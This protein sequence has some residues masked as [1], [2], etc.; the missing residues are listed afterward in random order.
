[1]GVVTGDWDRPMLMVIF[2]AGASYDSVPSRRPGSNIDP[3]ESKYR[4]PLANELFDDRPH[5][6]QAMTHFPKCQVIVPYLRK[7]TE[8]FSLEGELEKLRSEAERDPERHKQLAAVRFY[9]QFML[10]ECEDQ[11]KR[12]AKGITNYKTLLD[13]LRHRRKPREQIFLVTFNYDT[14]LEAALPTVGVEIRGVPD[15]IANDHYKAF[16]LHGSVNWTREVETLIINLSKLSGIQVSNQLIDRAADLKI[17]HKYHWL[18]DHP[19]PK[20]QTLDQDIA[21]FP[22]LAIPVES[23][24]DYE[25]PPEHLDCLLQCIPHVTK[26]LVIGWRA[27]EK[28]F[29]QLLSSNLQQDVSV[30]TVA[31][32][33]GGADQVIENLQKAGISGQFHPTTKGF[34]EFVE[35]RE[36]DEFLRS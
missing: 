34:T 27:A 17:G 5:F 30:L 33:S 21:L 18:K 2:G 26:L 22:A 16:K 6:V 28:D 35:N 29:C 12:V 24:V 20:L 3:N 7:R 15:Y 14:L 9:L 11:W 8:G 4:L 32:T 25:C 1:M 23:K 31:G 36:G 13:Q 19:I 10:W